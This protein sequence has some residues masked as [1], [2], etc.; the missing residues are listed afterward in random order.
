VRAKAR[1]R[2]Y[3]SFRS[4]FS[5]MASIRLE[6]RI[7]DAPDLIDYIPYIDPDERTWE[8]LRARK[9]EMHYVQMS[10][11]KHLYILQDTKR[12]SAARGLAMKWPI[13]RDPWWVL[14][15]LAYLDAVQQ[16]SG[17]DLYWALCAA[18]WERGEDI[19]TPEVLRAAAEQVGLDPDRAVAA[20]DDE[21]LRTIGAD[22]LEKAYF[23]DVFGIPFFKVGR[24]KFWGLDRVDLFCDAV[25][26]SLGRPVEPVAPIPAP[27]TDDAADPLEGVPAEARELV[28]AYDADT[29]GGCG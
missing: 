26:E 1:P 10:K 2:F 18:R 27:E 3:F 23:D 12:L 22:G 5:W 29:A 25:L 7:P 20:P 4:P 21:A 24:H 11:A 8:T 28:G 14:P 15:H 16:G 19:C 9:V 17:R 6:E 13:D